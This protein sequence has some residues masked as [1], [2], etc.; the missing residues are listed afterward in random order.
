MTR[1]NDSG[2]A[3]GPV[4]VKIMSLQARLLRLEAASRVNKL[5]ALVALV[6]KTR[7]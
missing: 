1:W 6:E 4:L 7:G 5:E 3:L 2:P